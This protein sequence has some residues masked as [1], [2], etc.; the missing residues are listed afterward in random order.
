VTL[1]NARAGVFFGRITYVEILPRVHCD[2]IIGFVILNKYFL[3][4]RPRRACRAG[5]T[6]ISQKDV[7][8]A[9]EE[10][11]AELVVNEEEETA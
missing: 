7:G 4:D 11:F 6:P 5:H 10:E 8:F 3:V 1:D 2:V 9:N